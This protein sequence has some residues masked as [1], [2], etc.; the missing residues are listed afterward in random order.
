MT[1]RDTLE[2]QLVRRAILRMNAVTTGLGA[3]VLTGTGLLLAT[4]WLVIKG[5]PDP[6][7]HL[8]LLSQFLPGY[9][10]TFT[11]AIIGFLYAFVIGSCSGFVVARI[12]NALAR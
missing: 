11:G 9:S 12:Y 6:G 1:G 10:V 7:P 3:G 8:G 2:D 5:G 4:M